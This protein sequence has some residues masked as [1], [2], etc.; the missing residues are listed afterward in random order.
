MIFMMCGLE[1]LHLFWTYY[2]VESSISVN[3]STK[4]ARHTYDW[5]YPLIASQFNCHYKY[6]ISYCYRLRHLHRTASS[7]PVYSAVPCCLS[8]RN[9]L[10]DCTSLTAATADRAASCL[11]RSESVKFSNEFWVERLEQGSSLFLLP[12]I[13]S[14]ERTERYVFFDELAEL[15]R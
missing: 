8:N 13:L 1:V 15:P 7:S 14:S 6:Q 12:Q 5:F 4:I 10:V 9:S 2:I 11:N 3:I